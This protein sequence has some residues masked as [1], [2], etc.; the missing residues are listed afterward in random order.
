MARGASVLWRGESRWKKDFFLHLAT[1]C[2]LSTS[3]RKPTISLSW[4]DQQLPLPVVLCAEISQTSSIVSISA[5]SQTFPVQD[6]RSSFILRYAVS[7]VTMLP[8]L[9]R[10]LRNGFPIL[11]NHERG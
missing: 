2:S 7:L 4:Y 5:T 8:V 1:A 9:V 11:P 10:F 6:V 3:L